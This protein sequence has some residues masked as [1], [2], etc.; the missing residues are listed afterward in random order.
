V[1]ACHLSLRDA[2]G[3]WS[4][5]TTNIMTIGVNALANLS[6]RA[7]AGRRPTVTGNPL[8]LTVTP[9]GRRPGAGGLESDRA[10]RYLRL[11]YE[12]CTLTVTTVDA[13]NVPFR[14]EVSSHE[15]AC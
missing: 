8:R 13:R 3:Q 4:D 6:R 5:G 15:N 10:R 12:S 2:P 1:T 7:P 11:A 14:L 9:A